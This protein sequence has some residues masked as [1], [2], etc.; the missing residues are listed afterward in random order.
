MILGYDNKH[1]ELNIGDICKFKI[2]TIEYEGMVVYDDSEFAYV[3]E[4]KED[5]FPCVFMNKAN[6]GSIEKIINVWS[7]KPN[8]DDYGFYRELVNS[9][10]EEV[11]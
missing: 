5:N 3:F 7:I 8:K 11:Q 1:Q 4:M 6:L 10:R 2:G 9:N